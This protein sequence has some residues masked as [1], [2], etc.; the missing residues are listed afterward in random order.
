M[1]FALTKYGNAEKAAAVKS[2]IDYLTFKCTQNPNYGFTKIDP[3]S[4]LGKVATAQI[5][6]LGA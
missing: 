2:A 1:L 6:K 3:T 5:A 4:P